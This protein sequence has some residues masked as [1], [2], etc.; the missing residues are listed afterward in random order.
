MLGE[1]DDRPPLGNLPPVT[2][3][4]YSGFFVLSASTPSYENTFLTMQISETFGFEED[5]QHEG[6]GGIVKVLAH[7]EG[8]RF[9][10]WR[11][12]YEPPLQ[13]NLGGSR[14]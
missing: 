5:G 12:R 9:V 11:L 4:H 6:T 10:A 13:I 3:S 7:C 2:G 8:P 14:N 1:W